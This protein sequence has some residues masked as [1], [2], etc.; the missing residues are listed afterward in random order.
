MATSG[1]AVQTEL[2]DIGITGMT[3][4]IDFFSSMSKG[5][6]PAKPITRRA[7]Q[8]NSGQW[9]IAY[10]AEQRKRLKTSLKSVSTARNS[11][12][13]ESGVNWLTAPGNTPSARMSSARY[14]N[15]FDKEFL[16]VHGYVDKPEDLYAVNISDLQLEA[17]SDMELEEFINLASI[18]ASD[19]KLPLEIFEVFPSL[20]NLELSLNNIVTIS[21]SPN[22]FLALCT[23]DLSYNNLSNCSI[24]VLGGV[25]QLKELHLTGN[26]IVSLPIEMS[27]PQ[28]MKIND[29]E[30]LLHISF[31][32]LEKLW[33]DDN[34]LTDTATFAILAGLRK[35]KYLNLNANE[36]YAIPRLKLLSSS[37]DNLITKQTNPSV[38]PFPLLETLSIA[39]NMIMSAN[40]LIACNV[41][42]SLKELIITGNPL[43]NM[44]KGLPA[45]MK[46][47]LGKV[48]IIR[49][50]MKKKQQ[51]PLNTKK[52]KKVSVAPPPTIPRQPIQLALEPPGIPSLMMG[53]VDD[54][55][56]EEEE[57]RDSWSE[58]DSM[59]SSSR[60]DSLDVTINEDNNGPGIFMTQPQ[61][62]EHEDKRFSPTSSRPTTPQSLADEPHPLPS[63]DEEL[64]QRRLDELEQFQ[65]CPDKYKG[66]ESLLIKDTEYDDDNLPLP[67]DIHGT[68]KSLRHALRH[69]L[70][71][72]DARKNVSTT[73]SKEVLNY[74]MKT[75]RGS[76]Y[77]DT[78][79][80][81]TKKQNIERIMDDVMTHEV[82]METNLRDVLEMKSKK[83][84]PT[85][86]LKK[87]KKSIM[88]GQNL[89]HEVRPT[90]IVTVD[91]IPF[92]DSCNR[93]MLKFVKRQWKH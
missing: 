8:K 91:V 66:F 49:S 47:E 87:E 58:D 28:E 42:P 7:P 31:P 79:A 70:M 72:T 1:R 52:F 15:K 9:I 34:H 84:T 41:W 13:S 44:N 32:R 89:L 46:D 21:R 92:D 63:I 48:N 18:C 39:N 77:D 23:L 64:R 76:Q 29:N 26:N 80:I 93:N 73:P 56:E 4:S 33:L 50:V 14:H 62:D 37:G 81:S 27:R 75:L 25:P 67:K 90:I 30:K 65:N 12:L 19:N 71:L 88:E 38:D 69:P 35:L 24:T 57:M 22:S 61:G 43:V 51:I 59:T 40:G 45:I 83:N 2:H 36:L 60:K 54:D 78:P 82:T 17:Y 3:G 10:Q 74:T 6:F 85:K 53:G 5:G 11:F 86:E 55:D 16:M 68:T 20:E